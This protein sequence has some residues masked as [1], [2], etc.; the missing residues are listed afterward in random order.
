MRTFNDE[1]KKCGLEYTGHFNRSAVRVYGEAWGIE[2][3]ISR[4]G[5]FC[6][7]FPDVNWEDGAHL[8]ALTGR[9]VRVVVDEGRN[10]YALQH[11]TKDI[12]YVVKEESK[13]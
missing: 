10:I 13:A 11:I 1:I 7:L 9:Y 2:I 8:E 5:E 3:P 4:V 12:K 6:R